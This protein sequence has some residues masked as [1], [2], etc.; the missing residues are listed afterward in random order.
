MS[1]SKAFALAALIG[2]SGFFGCASVNRVD[3]NTVTDLSGNW[4][5][6]DSRLVSE[7]MITDCVS[8]PWL[9]AFKASHNGAKP[10]V[11]VGSIRNR[12]SEHI[13]TTT[14]S[15]NLEREL[16]NS[17][18]VRFVS[19]KEERSEIREE[20]NE[21]QANASAATMKRLRQET[22]ADFM[23]IGNIAQINDNSGGT[24]AKSYQVNLEL[25][26][27]E[28][29]EKAWIGTKDIKKMVK[30]SSFGF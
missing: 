30:K 12:S 8:R 13:D 7:Q 22:G 21:Q 19:N 28:S 5:D 29:T 18:L 10:T 25:H 6:T 16:I 11:I 9:A 20:R 23:L 2:V 3:P 4:N 24:T 17:G 1:Y 15:K 14:F 27:M 26:D